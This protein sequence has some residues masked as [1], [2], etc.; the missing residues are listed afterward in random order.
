[1]RGQAALD[2]DR[3]S[4][5]GSGGQ[6]RRGLDAVGDDLG[7]DRREL[8][9]AVDGHVAGPEAV[10][11]RPAL[12]QDL[13][14]HGDVGLERHVLEHGGSL[15]QGG[16]HHELRGRPHRDDVEAEAG[17][18]ELH[19][20]AEDVAVVDVERG[21]H[22]L[23]PL[24]V[25]VHRARAP[26][27]AAGQRHARG[28]EAPE[29]RPE[30]VDAGAHGAHQVVGRLDRGDVR[31]I[32][33]AAVVVELDPGAEVLEH[34]RHGARVGKLRHV[35]QAMHAGGEQGRRHDRES[36]V[37]GAADRHPTGE[38]PAPADDQ[39]VHCGLRCYEDI[40]AL[41]VF[42]EVPTRIHGVVRGGPPRSF[43]ESGG[44]IN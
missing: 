18:P 35:A 23:Q 43:L 29:Q 16:R 13:A 3:A 38:F 42:R 32:D 14:E 22:R 31:G 19:V 39:C 25:E 34:A 37:L 28:A 11:A 21:A 15:G 41:V 1:M 2:R 8:A 24:E 30:H 12:D 17:S 33:G 26:G 6:E 7:I 27:A 4:G 44:C 20:L 5:D 10:D 9:H 36:G 40:G